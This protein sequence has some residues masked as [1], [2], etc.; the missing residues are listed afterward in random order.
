M[1]NMKNMN[2]VLPIALVVIVVI[3]IL[4]FMMRR[5]SE[6]F[7]VYTSSPGHPSFPYNIDG[8]YNSAARQLRCKKN[9]RGWAWGPMENGQCPPGFIQTG[10]SATWPK[11]QCLGCN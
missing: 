11:R 1:M 6:N 4:I 2:T 3:I 7:Q 10:V 8:S 5:S 9:G